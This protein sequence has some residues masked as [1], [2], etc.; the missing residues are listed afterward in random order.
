MENNNEIKL[1]IFNYMEKIY[2]FFKDKNLNIRK[3]LYTWGF[4]IIGISL[5]KTF[6]FTATEAMGWYLF[7]NALF[8]LNINFNDFFKLITTFGFI[9]LAIGGFIGFKLGK[10]IENNKI[11]TYLEEFKIYLA[12]KDK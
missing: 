8:S 4:A 2:T 1:F 12:E 10:L 5:I 7:W 9:K 3:I 6:L 11:N